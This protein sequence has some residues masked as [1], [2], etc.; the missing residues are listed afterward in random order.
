MER[1]LGSEIFGFSQV[2]VDGMNL[3]ARMDY[4]DLSS[5]GKKTGMLY[6]TFRQILSLKKKHPGCTIRFL[7]EG[8]K[9]WRQEKYP[10]YKANRAKRR[11]EE[12]SRRF[13]ERVEELQRYLPLAG[14]YQY[15]LPGFEGDDLA[16]YFTIA[17]KDQN[18]LL[19]SKD[20][21]WWQLM[22]FDGVRVLYSKSI[23]GPFEA[24]KELGFPVEKLV[25]YKTLTGDR[26][27]GIQ[28]ISRFPHKIAAEMVCDCDHVDEFVG[29]LDSHGHS[30]WAR[31]VEKHG[32]LLRQNEDLL[33]LDGRGVDARQI[34]F[35]DGEWDDIGLSNLFHRFSMDSLVS[36][37]DENE[38]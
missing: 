9:S 6:G 31:K 26:S 12:D 7:W 5:D 15:R 36:M 22:R 32:W 30:N 20:Q 28:G 37:L 19:V 2:L 18:T 25:L 34:E 1:D 3:A 14:V 16:A 23:L 38:L 13:F 33:L 10:F 17:Y 8:G 4:M 24:E 35:T 29:W 11:I 27:D 21:D